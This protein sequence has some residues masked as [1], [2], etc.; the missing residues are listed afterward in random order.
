M[1]RTRIIAAG[2]LLAIITIADVAWNG[3]ALVGRAEWVLRTFTF[4]IPWVLVCALIGAGVGLL[5]REREGILWCGGIGTLVGVAAATIFGFAYQGYVVDHTYAQRIEVTESVPDLT[6]RAPW[7]LADTYASRDQGDDVGDRGRVRHVPVAGSATSRY[8]TLI[9]GRDAMGRVGYSSVRVY[10][11]PKTG[12]IPQGAA[13]SCEVPESMTKRWGA[14]W[15]TRSLNR[16]MHLANPLLH[17]DESDLYAYCKDGSPVVV[18]PLWRYEGWFVVTKVAA[19]VAVYDTEG[20]RILDNEHV[21]EVEGPTFPQSLAARLRSSLPASGSWSDWI[22][23][24]GGYDTSD[25]D[26]GDTNAGNTTEI[27]LVGTDKNF[28]YVTPLTPR[29]TSQN[30]T[31]LLHVDARTGRAVVSTGLNLPATSSIENAIR[32][33]SVS[34]DPN[35]ATRWSSGMR[36]YEMV[37]ASGGHWVASIGL[38]QVVNY[39]ADISPDGS[40]TVTNTDGTATGKPTV[41]VNSGK[42]LSQMTED[43]LVALIEAAAKELRNR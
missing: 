9:T 34:G 41:E 30:L 26:S 7:V 38:G 17:F 22:S 39:R 43:E 20:F 21:S 31:A 3:W 40:V 18:M 36:V 6:D 27:G 5:S 37:P 16:E 29:G 25:K 4:A 24:R 15:P 11:L 12:P 10:D 33:A 42:P 1:N 23:K 2:I 14:F 19:G 28:R 35:W 32:S 13:T 8:T